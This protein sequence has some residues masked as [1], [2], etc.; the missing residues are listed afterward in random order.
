MQQDD[1]RSLL[2]NDKF[3]NYDKDYWFPTSLLKTVL[4]K[5]RIACEF[6]VQYLLFSLFDLQ[7]KPPQKLTE[8]NIV[9]SK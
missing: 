7:S 1:K 6:F 8:S 2:Q 3:V 5:H 9:Y 4:A